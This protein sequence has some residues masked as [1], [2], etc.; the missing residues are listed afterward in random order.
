MSLDSISSSSSSSSSSSIT[1]EI[2]DHMVMNYINESQRLLAM[3]KSVLVAVNNSVQHD[4]QKR[5]RK[6]RETVPRN[7][8]AAHDNLVADYFSN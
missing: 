5:P 7:R 2:Y 8:E 6:R 1:D 4:N 3:Q